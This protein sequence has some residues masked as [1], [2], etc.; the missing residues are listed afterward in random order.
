MWR[1]TIKGL[2]AHKVRLGLTALAIVLGVGFMAGTFVLTDTMNKTFDDLF[3]A[4]AAGTDV[5]VRATSGFETNLGGPGGGGGVEERNPIPE[6][7]LTLVRAVPGVKSATGDVNGYAQIVDPRTGEAIGGAGP[8]TL[9]TSWNGDTSILELRQGTAPTGADE[10][11]IDAATADK[12]GLKV[13]DRVQILFQGPARTFTVSGVV[14]FGEADNLAG[15]TLALFDLETAQEVLGRFGQLDDITVVAEDAVSATALRARIAAALPEGYEAVTG[16][17]VADEQSVALK[18][19]LGFFKSALLVFAF[20]SLFVGAFI[21]FNTFSII[22]AQRTREL[23]LLRTLG[24]TPR[25][26][27][28]S[29]M[30]EAG[31]TGLVA[32]AVGIGAGLLVAAGLQAMLKAFGIDLPSTKTQVLPRTIVASV[33]VGTVV[34]FVSSIMPARRASRVTPIQALLDVQPVTSGSLRRRIVTGV[35]VTGLGVAALL[36]GLFGGGSQAGALVGLGTAVTFVGVAMLSPLF[37]RPLAGAIGAPLPR[38]GIPGKLS[39]ENAMRNPRRTASTAAALMIGL[40]LVVFVTIFAASLK[41]SAT[42]AL[43]ETLKADFI[44][45]TSQFTGFS[46]DVAEQLRRSPEVG[47]VSPFRQ[48]QFRLNGAAGFVTAVE[49]ES[50]GQV[51]SM[52]M[53][54]GSIDSL[55]HGG[56][57]VHRDVAEQHGWKVGDTIRLEFARTGMRDLTVG[58]IYGDDRLLG[59]Y[60]ISIATYQANF[61]DQLDAVVFVNA[62]PGVPISET[63]DA[64]S[65]VVAGFPNIEVSDQAQFKEKQAG[66][67]DQLLGLV[68][69]LLGLAILIALFGIANTLGLSIFERTREIGLLRAVGMTRRQVRSMIRWESVIM[70]VLGALLGVAIGVFFGWAMTRALADQGIREFSVPAGQL[71]V[72]VV[73]AGVAGVLA[74]VLPARRAAKLNVLEAIAFE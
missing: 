70:A 19:G 60:V 39:R 34:T 49:P 17:T 26:V 53:L 54:E 14:G 45:S 25:Q 3:K 71:L 9:G 62:A 31:I 8:P 21:I 72:Y 41:A 32:S 42:A 47:A 52:E 35:T 43:D 68:S 22:V 16:A 28:V 15:A 30:A 23:G 4:G 50:I 57:L 46:H 51:A 74:A 5:V 11:A 69:A 6:Q 56:V 10:V 40:G 27:M 63:R 36:T 29:V 1:A 64:V 66:F 33:V 37:A 2:I 73:L 7:L 61:I 24:A 13:G 65:G 20:V 18:E 59:D 44:L 55:D 12:H 58:G 48:G 67:I 38:L